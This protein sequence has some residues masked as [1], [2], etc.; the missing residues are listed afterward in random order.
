M[1]L[2]WHPDRETISTDVAGCFHQGFEVYCMVARSV[3][4]VLDIAVPS[5]FVIDLR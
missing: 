2:S 4:K 3:L 5:I 1:V